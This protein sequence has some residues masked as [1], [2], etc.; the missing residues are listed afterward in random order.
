M[1]TIEN[2]YSEQSLSDYTSSIFVPISYPILLDSLSRVKV[3]MK[4][5]VVLHTDEATFTNINKVERKWTPFN[6]GCVNV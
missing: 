4:N 3:S 5:E 1:Q 6:G 2:A